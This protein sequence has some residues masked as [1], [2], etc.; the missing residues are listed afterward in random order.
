MA[1][2]IGNATVPSSGT[3][4]LFSLPAS[5][6]NVTLWQIGTGLAYIGTSKTV[7]STSG[8]QCHSIPTSFFNYVGNAGGTLWA[9]S[10][11]TACSIQY[12]LVTNF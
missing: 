1:V 8:L 3:V 12:I 4:S 11:G 10:N 6:C 2:I 5:Q 7:S 9:T